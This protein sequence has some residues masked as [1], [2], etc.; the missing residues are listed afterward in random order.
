MELAVADGEQRC[1]GNGDIAGGPIV[2]V[3]VSDAVVCRIA[4]VDGVLPVV[5]PTVLGH[6]VVLPPIRLFSTTFLF[7]F[8]T[9]FLRERTP[10]RGI[11]R[12]ID[13]TLQP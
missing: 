7:I 3:T 4:P 13:G 6:I 8:S 1:V 12:G 2:P 5:S 9:F 11:C 10:Y